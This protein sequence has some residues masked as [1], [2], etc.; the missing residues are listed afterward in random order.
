MKLFRFEERML[1]EESR[2]VLPKGPVPA[3]TVDFEAFYRELFA[4][5][6]PVVAFGLRGAI[7]L[8]AL[9]PLF[10]LARLRL[11]SGLLPEERDLL[12]TRASEH[13]FYFLRQAAM[14]LKTFAC[15]AYFRDPRVRQ[16]FE[17]DR[18]SEREG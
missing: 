9:L 12:L 6:P 2:A 10:L 14:A 3:E 1:V 13:R 4:A 11:F 8:F 15:M 18:M 5:A 7:W 16:Y 17:L